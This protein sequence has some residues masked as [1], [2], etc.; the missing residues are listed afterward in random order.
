MTSA[1]NRDE[2]LLDAFVRGF[3]ATDGCVVMFPGYPIEPLLTDET[4]EQGW[5]R[6][7]PLAVR[8]GSKALDDLNGQLPGR[9]PHLFE[10]LLLNWRWAE[11]DVGVCTLYANPPGD[12]LGGWLAQVRAGHDLWNEL[13]ARGFVRFGRGPESDYDPVCFDLNRRRGADC[14]VVR[15]DHEAIL[16]RSKVEILAELAPNF[17]TF[18]EESVARTADLCHK[19]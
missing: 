1:A 9:L 2:L 19:R 18:I 16:C 15:L 13:A 10:K 3:R 6:W 17:R 4:D 12:D 11:V 8:T 5:R 14:P 7:H